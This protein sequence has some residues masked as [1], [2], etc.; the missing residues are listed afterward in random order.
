MFSSSIIFERTLWRYC[1]I[2]YIMV[3]VILGK[4]KQDQVLCEVWTWFECYSFDFIY[5]CHL[6]RGEACIMIIGFN[7]Y[8]SFFVK[9]I[10]IPWDVLLKKCLLWLLFCMKVY[11][12]HPWIVF[13]CYRFWPIFKDAGGPFCSGY[14]ESIITQVSKGEEQAHPEVGG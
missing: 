7:P 14:C 6:D 12:P 13:F 3:L 11:L 10:I 9:V 1:F 2:F 4:W 8:L 5:P